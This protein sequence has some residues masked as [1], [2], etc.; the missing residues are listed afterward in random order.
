MPNDTAE[1]HG[2]SADLR[3]ESPTAE[4][5]TTAFRAFKALA[6]A[7]KSCG[8]RFGEDWSLHAPPN[9]DRKLLPEEL[10]FRELNTE[11]ETLYNIAQRTPESENAPSN[12]RTTK[13][14]RLSGSYCKWFC[15]CH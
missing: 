4:Q 5:F 2:L 10:A 1:S 13:S 11:F 6:S 7:L 14:K 8:A 3:C 15:C 12:V 9:E